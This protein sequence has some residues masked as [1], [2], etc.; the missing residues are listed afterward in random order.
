[1]ADTTEVMKND[2]YTHEVPVF[3]D[4][5]EGFKV[6]DRVGNTWIDFTS[7]IFVANVGHSAK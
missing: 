1:M 3:W 4:K 2:M 5:A 7:G 6:Q